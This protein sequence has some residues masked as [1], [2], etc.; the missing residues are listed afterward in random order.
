MPSIQRTA[1]LVQE[2]S[3]ASREQNTGADQINEAIRELDAVIQQNASAST[4]SAS[5]AE[6]LA[7]QAEQLRATV[8]FFRLGDESASGPGNDAMAPARAMPATAGRASAVGAA[9]T[10]RDA[11]PGKTAQTGTA[12]AD[13]KPGTQL[14]PKTAPE[15]GRATPPGANG[16][17]NGVAL[18]LG[19]EEVSDAEFERY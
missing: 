8:S 3:A 1:D 2:I 13:R 16:A 6:N 9:L 18:D 5:V 19:A 17:G 14:R 4:E 11:R 10:E 7:S 15:T 12:P